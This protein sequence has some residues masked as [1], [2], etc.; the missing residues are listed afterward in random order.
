ENTD[1][2]DANGDWPGSVTRIK[3][4]VRTVLDAGGKVWVQEAGQSN[5]TAD[6]IAALIS[7][8]VAEAVI[9][10]NVIV[11]Q[12]SDWNENMT[13]PADLTYVK[14]KA[15]YVAI[16]DGNADPGDYSSRAYRGPETPNY[17]STTMSFLIDAKSD[18]NTN[19][20]TKA[21]W[22]EADRIVDEIGFNASYS[23]IP[24]GGV[25]FSDCCEN[26]WIFNIGSDA[27]SVRKFWDRYVTKEEDVVIPPGTTVYQEAN[28]MVLMDVESAPIVWGWEEETAIAGYL[29]T[30]Y[31]TATADSFNTPG[32][33]LLEYTFQVTNAGDYQFQWRS[34][35]TEGDSYTD[36]NDN[37]VRLV[38]AN[39]NPVVPIENDLV[40][41]GSEQ[42]YKVYMNTENAWVWHAKNHDNNPKAIAWNL[43]ADKTYNVQVSYRSKGH[44]IDRLL[45]WNRTGFGYSFGDLTGA[46]NNTAAL[47]ALPLSP[48]IPAE[49]IRF[50]ALTDFD[51]S[52]VAAGD[53]PYYKDAARNALAID[54]A[55]GTYRDRFAR[56]ILTETVSAGAY[57]VTITAMREL[58]GECTY[59]L[60]VDGALI[61]SRVNSTT[62]EDY[63]LQDHT[64]SNVTI[65]ADAEIIV[66]SNSTSNE[67]IPENGGWAYAR[68]RW[69]SLSFAP[70]GADHTDDA[71][72]ININF[73][74]WSTPGVN[75]VFGA[76]Q[77]PATYSGTSWN[78]LVGS[79]TKSNL[80]DSMGYTT[81]VGVDVAFNGT[82]N[83]TYDGHPGFTV[84]NEYIHSSGVSPFTFSGLND[85][86][87]YDITFIGH[88]NNETDTT[89]FTI[90][91]TSKI[92]A[93]VDVMATSWA[94]G[95][96]FV[97]FSGLT[98]DSN[99]EIT[100][101]YEV[102]S[103]AY[104][105][106]A[107]IQI[108]PAAGPTGPP[109][110]ASSGIGESRMTVSAGNL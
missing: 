40:P 74:K 70:A 12:H 1:W 62:T 69:T 33:G 110:M 101:T 31:Y 98:V 76:D 10:E 81:P 96:N 58:D 60:Y 68:G 45:L 23:V 89:K 30:S 6:W 72:V 29:G 11:V 18:S 15:N 5:M 102:D 55:E 80:I 54:A 87:S 27:D 43:E 47:D 103:G 56:A 25:D 26:W 108:V 24:G 67:E 46:A 21:L 4:K 59:Q 9:K 22:T 109:V 39:G 32:N 63:A 92:I 73:S 99:G 104:A 16:D 49:P 52:S 3:N 91:G 97:I 66:K 106:I 65:S 20:H 64:F 51:I 13:A 94:E 17:T 61:G 28:G 85:G 41:T 7:D 84:L 79:G 37:F 77:G 93:P 78:N 48:E 57:D 75:T 35:I 105:C 107:G 50:D 90:G 42:W 38:D 82:W 88:G 2:T 8:G 83:I 95:E 36:Y 14:D 53:V 71:Q 34:R 19:A 86:K 100:G 44:G